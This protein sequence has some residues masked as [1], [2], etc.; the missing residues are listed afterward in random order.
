VRDGAAL[1]PSGSVRLSSGDRVLLLAE[2]EDESAL[3]DLFEKKQG[4]RPT[5]S[6]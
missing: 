6:R 5:P 3:A 2:A 1:Q 4:M